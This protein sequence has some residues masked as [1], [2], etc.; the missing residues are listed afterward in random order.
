MIRE[1]T[2][3]W[4]PLAAAALYLALAIGSAATKAPFGDEGFYAAPSYT[5]L[6]HGYLGVP[7]SPV[8]GME[9]HV[10]SIPPMFFLTQAAWYAVAGLNVIS[11]RLADV[12]WGLALMAGLYAAL[13]RVTGEE[14][15]ALLAAGMLGADYTFLMNSTTGRPDVM[16]AALGMCAIAVFLYW[17]EQRL[18]LAVVVSQTLLVLSGLT[19]PV[20]GILWALG[21][22]IVTIGYEGKR[23]LRP[24]YIAL[25]ALPYL[26]GAAAWGAYILR[27]PADFQAQFLG[28]ALN[29]NRTK[30]LQS[31]LDALVREVTLRY[32]GYYGP[33]PAAPGV[34]VLRAMLPLG[35]LGGLLCALTV[36]SLRAR[37]VV[38][39]LAALLGVFALALA[40]VDGTK[41]LPYLIHLIPLAV[42]VLAATLWY[43]RA[44][45]MVVA[46]LVILQVGPVLYRVRLNPY[47]KLYQPTVEIL[48]P[49]VSAGRPV[50]A[51]YQFSIPLGFPN[52]LV[53][54]IHFGYL[55]G[56]RPD[57][58]QIDKVVFDGNLPGLEAKDPSEGAFLRK[59]V[60]E[61]FRPVW[62]NSAY[63]VY[64]RR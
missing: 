23:V 39:R 34:S 55:S 12:L 33:S 56:S 5:L 32:F 52:N 19:H 49:F 38:R 13:K 51:D 15:L 35:Y 8:Y 54:D 42:A 21:L 28:I 17:R 14:G 61:D 57:A 9:R 48:R 40:L 46:A 47:R 31:P 22:L 26:A 36:P 18:G 29:W 11:M 63:R 59:L 7:A 64:V 20:G 37:R 58:I 6:T 27:S 4:A 24:R 50:I 45:W 25:A 2:P 10:Y 62:E 30:A 43:M 44:S 1:K 16:S 3:R 53:S 41:Q 60:T